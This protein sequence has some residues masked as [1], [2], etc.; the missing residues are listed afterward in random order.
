MY[1]LFVRCLSCHYD[2]RK[3]AQHRCSECGREFDPSNPS[4]FTSEQ[5]YLARRHIRRI[6]ITT[7]ILLLPLFVVD[8]LLGP[9]HVY[10]PTFTRSPYYTAKQLIGL[11]GTAIIIV[12]LLRLFRAQSKSD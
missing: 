3:L 4:T 5:K 12:Q 1:D 8:Y 10:A 7:V 6:I 11:A 9:T 2:L